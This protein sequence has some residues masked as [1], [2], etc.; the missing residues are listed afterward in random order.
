[1]ELMQLRLP[2]GFAVTYHKFYDIDPILESDSDWFIENWGYFTEDLLQVVKLNVKKGT[3]YIPGRETNNYVLFDLG[4]Y[5]DSDINGHYTLE[6]VDGQWNV[7][8]NIS[9]KDRYII[10]Q[11]IE[12]WLDEYQR[13]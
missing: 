5:P 2:A 1:M 7:I 11:K 8:K 9:T 13:V 10:K 4:W 12:E 6:I 3:W